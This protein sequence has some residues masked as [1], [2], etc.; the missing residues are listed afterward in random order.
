MTR[1]FVKM[2]HKV[3]AIEPSALFYKD[4]ISSCSAKNFEGHKMTL[5][6]YAELTNEYF[7]IIYASGVT[8]YL[9]DKELMNFMTAISRLL[10]PWGLLCIRDLGHEK[11]LIQSQFEIN[12]TPR[13]LIQLAQKTGFS[14]SRWRR[15]YPFIFPNKIYEKWPNALT[16]SLWN[17]ASASLF[18]PMWGIFATSDIPRGG[19]KCF[20]VYLFRMD[21]R[22]DI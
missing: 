10:R 20:F 7:D 12:R 21:E 2:A 6:Q 22:C 8:P 19:R 9:A 18:Y 4:L 3:V 1:H 17:I 13:Q 15:V 5:S 11:M 16:K 14:C